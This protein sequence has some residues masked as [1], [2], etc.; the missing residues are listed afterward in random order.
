MM[1]MRRT[2][3]L[4]CTTMLAGFFFGTIV[5]A[6]S[7][8][9]SSADANAPQVVQPSEGGVNWKGVG[10]GAGTVASNL[11]YVPAKLA[12]GILGGIA[13]G[14]GY[15]LTGGNKQVA[16][17]I[18]R[19]SLGGDYVLTPEKIT[20]EKPIYFSGPSEAAT[21]QNTAP[22]AIASPSGSNETPSSPS[23]AASPSLSSAGVSAS[24]S[25]RPIDSGAGPV[26][27]ATPAPIAEPAGGANYPAAS[28]STSHHSEPLKF[29]SSP[30]PDTS[31]E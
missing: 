12:Y 15:A 18:W 22:A 11:V 25:T 4:T 10:I 23:A 19:S 17:S 9:G 13:G 1:R 31:I 6:Q 5:L 21:T 27:G 7:D 24:P 30:L 29:K 3:R 16:D 8:G 28:Y 26:S 20:G 14:A 2:A